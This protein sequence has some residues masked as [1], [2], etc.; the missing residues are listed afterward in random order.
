L[1]LKSVSLSQGNFRD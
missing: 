1:D